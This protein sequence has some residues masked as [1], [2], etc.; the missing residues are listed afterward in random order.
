[1]PETEKRSLSSASLGSREDFGDGLVEVRD[2]LGDEGPRATRWVQHVLVQRVG[3]HLSHHGPSQPVR[4]VVLA[5]LTAL[6]GRYYRLVQD[7][8]DVVGR[9]LPVEPC[10]ASGE[11]LEHGQAAHLRG[12][13][14][15]VRFHN[16]L[17][18]RLVAEVAAVQQVAWVGLSQV[19]DV[20]S[21]TRLD[22][23]S[24]DC[25]QVG[26]ADEQIVHLGGAAC[27][28]AECGGK[29]VFPQLP[30]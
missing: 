14:E 28:F 23:H 30:S 26:V 29:Q 21:E 15:E 20:G 25:G 18:P 3:H 19:A 5:Q 13:G 17:Q 24:D 16:P 4:G 2:R 27:Y 1:M 9:L 6:V 8:R 12:P 10:D 22:D 11:G 7:G